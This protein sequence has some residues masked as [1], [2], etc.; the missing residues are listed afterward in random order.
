MA[1]AILPSGPRTS[2]L[3]R[4]LAPTWQRLAALSINWELAAYGAI[5]LLALVLRVWDVGARAMHHDESLHAYYAWQFFTGQGYQYD[6]LMHGPFQ[7]EVAPIFY[8]LFGSSEFSARLLAVV[9]GTVLVF[10]PFF[11]RRYLTA[12]G[13]L[14]A[15]LMLAIS[16]AFVYFSRFIRDDIYIACFSLLLFVCLVRYLE[17]PRPH[18]L[19]IA[20]A[21][22]AMAM[23]SMEAAYLTFFMFGSFLI[24]QGIR[25]WIGQGG[26]VLSAMRETSLDTW[27]TTLAIFVVLTVLFYS[28]FFT[29]PDGIWDTSQPLFSSGASCGLTHLTPMGL[30]PC[31]KDILGGITYW[32]AQHGV[33]RG[34]QPWFYYL[35]ILPLYEQLALLFGAAGLIWCAIR[36]SFFR[37]FLAW[38]GVMAYALYTWAGEK[39]PWLTIHIALPLILLAGLFL[40]D[41]VRSGRMRAVISAAVVFVVLLVLE[42]HGT[43]VLNFVDGANPT[44]M[45]IYVQTSQDVPNVVNEIKKMPGWPNIPIGLDNSDVGGWPFIWYLRDDR[46][47]SE[48]TAFGGPACNG[49]YCP[50]LLMLG[51]TY[52][53][54]SS[55]LAKRYVV[56]KYR[57]NWWFPE[58]YKTWFPAHCG[59]TGLSTSCQLSSIPNLLGTPSDWSHVWNWLIYR[60]PFGDRGARDMYVLVRR[61][62]VPGSKYFSTSPSTV[63]STTA[64]TQPQSTVA[65]LPSTLLATVSTGLY[66][67]RGI[68][69]D[70]AGNLYVADTLNHRIAVYNPRGRLIRTW[71]SAGTGPGQFSPRDSPQDVT[72]G[73]EGLVYA[74][75]TWNQRVEV[76]TAKGHLVRTW[77][78][79]PI[80]SQP[81]QFY[82][83][84]GIV[85]SSAGRVYVADTGNKR[86]QVFSKG[87]RYL[88]SFGTAGSGSG[89]F[90][91]PSSVALGPHGTVYV[92]DFWNQR[93]QVFTS[94]GAYV[95]S[96][97]VT[98]WTSGSYDEPFLAVDG[99][100]GDVYASDP[101]QQEVL[102]FS[103]TGSTLG[104]M[105]NS[106][107]TMPIGVTVTGTGNVAIS[108]PTANKVSLFRV[109][110]TAVLQKLPVTRFH[111]TREP[112]P[113]RP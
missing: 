13:A 46:S 90:N 2:W 6:P 67:P 51:P 42:V 96:W 17:S 11:L 25:E 48:T 98:D 62:L 44:E 21:S 3:D 108:D 88:F 43:F 106:A 38:W 73:P 12:P 54:Y 61:D 110:R 5:V 86:I 4:P 10:L 95:R 45:L 94:A 27:L 50:I 34:G 83:P 20:A 31:R 55:Q 99:A 111:P 56:Q 24:F 49:Q 97:P 41:L 105:Q 30:N 93:I 79:G 33:D 18:W 109:G 64:P 80:G 9:L 71:G 69:S 91:E 102:R 81:G 19:Y 26:P 60:T 15:S 37:T 72:V 77:G 58:D 107:L 40:G 63:G 89:Q 78:G 35:L 85:V 104:A 66:G 113:K 74:V 65:R 32:L 53:Q 59:A 101:Q 87:G 103:A 75:D 57:W 23:A 47:I 7:F 29:N 39:M 14:L 8:L 1:E 76:F 36:R 52:D 28:T 16:P 112:P 22:A 70:R 82:G 100:T 92:S 84:R 68:A